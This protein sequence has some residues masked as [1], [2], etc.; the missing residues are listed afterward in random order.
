MGIL[1]AELVAVLFLVQAP[2][3]TSGAASAILGLIIVTGAVR[4]ARNDP[5][6]FARLVTSVA[7]VVAL[8]AG[9]V[10]L[11]YDGGV[12]PTL[13]YLIPSLLLAAAGGYYGWVYE[14]PEP[15]TNVLLQWISADDIVEVDGVQLAVGLDSLPNAHAPGMISVYVQ[16]CVDAPRTVRLKLEDIASGLLQ[17]RAGLELC[18]DGD[19]DLGPGDVGRLMLPF[20]WGAAK[21]GEARIYL[22]ASASGPGGRRLI[23]FRAKPI[24]FRTKPGFQVFALLG[25]YIVTGGGVYVSVQVPEGHRQSGGEPLLPAWVAMS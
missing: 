24:T 23:R 14:W 1:I 8:I 25:G 7:G 12:V 2:S 21:P 13:P 17:S 20:R 16:S 19:F 3:L 6:W 15:K 9:V 4:E 10:A 18:P 5:P 22:E 11:Q